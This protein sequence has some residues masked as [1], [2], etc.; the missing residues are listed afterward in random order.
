MT[1]PAAAILI[2]RPVNVAIA[3]LSILLAAGL[4]RPFVFSGPVVCAM[5]AG[6]LITAG[7]NVINDYYDLAIDRI[8]KP[9]RMLPAGRMSPAGARRYAIFLFACGV[10]FS[11]FASLFGAVIALI[12][13]LLLVAYSRWFK[14]QPVIGNLT[15]SLAT[16][17][18]FIFGALAAGEGAMALQHTHLPLGS[19]R[20]GIFPAVFSFLFHFGREVIKDIEDQ[21]GDHAAGART[22]PLAFGLRPAQLIASSAF[23]ILAGVVWLPHLTGMYRPPYLWIILAGVYPAIAFA[24]W[25]L[26][27]NPDVRRMRL[28]SRVLKADML[29]GLLAIYAGTDGLLP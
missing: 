11:I 17:L 29:V 28:T 2:T 3:G 24:L 8:N 19:W 25:Q 27:Q 21:A 18:S 16:A 15:V 12:T 1:D 20:P 23:I 22:L 13:S 6:M 5:L 7:A 26:W 4:V 9:G 10:I 14:R